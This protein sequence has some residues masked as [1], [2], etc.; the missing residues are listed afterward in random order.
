[1]ILLMCTGVV[2]GVTRIS[3]PGKSWVLMV[4]AVLSVGGLI[5]FVYFKQRIGLFAWT[6][7]LLAK[8]RIRPT[9][10]K[11][12]ADRI[13]ETDYYISLFHREHPGAFFTVLF[14]YMGLGFLWTLE[15]QITLRLLGVSGVSFLESFLIMSLGNLAFLLPA[16]PAAIGTYEATYVG[17]FLLLGLGSGAAIALTLIRRILAIIWAGAG[18]LAMAFFRRGKSLSERNLLFRKPEEID[19]YVKIDDDPEG[20]KNP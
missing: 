13:K 15:I 7:N 10:L 3:L 17:I 5:V 1:M 9:F 2:L 11:K 18:L 8:L 16:I 14:L 19:D 4:A 12:N 20:Q 6:Q